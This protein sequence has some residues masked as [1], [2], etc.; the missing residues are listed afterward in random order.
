MP[1]FWGENNDIYTYIYIYFMAILRLQHA[2]IHR[3]DILRFGWFVCVLA[4]K[5]PM[6]TV[7]WEMKPF[8]HICTSAPRFFLLD[9]FGT[10]SCFWS[11]LYCWK[12][13]L[14]S[15]LLEGFVFLF[16][17]HLLDGVQSSKVEYFLCQKRVFFSQTH[18]LETTSGMGNSWAHRTAF[19]GRAPIWK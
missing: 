13:F 7:K 9:D 11:P 12:L 2:S 1:L 16:D 8:V 17:M 19:H 3:L 6:K 10:L 15:F 14:I 4:S 5:V 18:F